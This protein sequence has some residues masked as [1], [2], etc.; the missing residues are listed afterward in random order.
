M[1]TPKEIQQQC[2]NWWKDVLIAHIERMNYFPKE[3]NRIGK[4]TAKD[5]LEKLPEYQK[6]IALLRAHSKSNKRHGYCVVEI[7]R[8]FEKIGKQSVPEKIIIET[9][10]DYLKITKKEE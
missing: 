1:I 10:D 6:S 4:I 3:I 9:L 2:L 7:E 8:T 5:L